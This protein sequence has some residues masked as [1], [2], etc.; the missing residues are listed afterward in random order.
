MMR[1]TE[2]WTMTKRADEL[3]KLAQWLTRDVSPDL[4][5]R[6]AAMA[7]TIRGDRPINWPGLVQEAHAVAGEATRVVAARGRSE[8]AWSPSDTSPV[9]SM[10]A[11]SLGGKAG[12]QEIPT[13]SGWTEAR[14]RYAQ[15][16]TR[17]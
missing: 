6:T 3:S 5:R 10:V 7:R 9:H 14:D 1:R 16:L 2:M 15:E 11:D 13:P 4:G 12:I 8:F 17:R